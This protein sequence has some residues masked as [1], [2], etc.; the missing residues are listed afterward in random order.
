MDKSCFLVGNGPSQNNV[1]LSLLKSHTTMA[2]NDI[3]HCLGEFTPTYWGMMDLCFIESY[4]EDIEEIQKKGTIVVTSH[5]VFN[6]PYEH[7]QLQGSPALLSLGVVEFHTKPPFYS[8][9]TLSFTLAQWLWSK[10]FRKFNMIGFDSP[11]ARPPKEDH[12][13]PSYNH[14]LTSYTHKTSPFPEDIWKTGWEIGRDF[15]QA[16]EGEIWD[17][18]DGE[19]GVFPKRSL[20]E[21]L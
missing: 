17:V 6:Q 2:M 11:N 20:E 13:H 12:Y 18:S 5:R 16:N 21:V 14:K 7:I 15:I 9:G 4:R 8:I 1:D 19:L 10:G 3:T